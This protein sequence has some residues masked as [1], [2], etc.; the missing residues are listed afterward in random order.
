MNFAHYLTQKTG[1]TPREAEEIVARIRNKALQAADQTEADFERE[2]GDRI[3]FFIHTIGVTA[4]TFSTFPKMLTMNRNSSDF[5]ADATQKLDV[6]NNHFHITNEAIA[7]YPTLLSL[8]CDPDSTR[9]SSINQ[10]M[11]YLQHELGLSISTINYQPKLFCLDTTDVNN[12]TSLPYKVN[13]YRQV[14]GLRASDIRRSPNILLLDCYHDNRP[15]CVKCKIRFFEEYVGLGAK[16]LRIMPLLLCLDCDKNS[17]N[18]TSI[19]QKMKNLEQMGITKKAWVDYPAILAMDCNPHST[20]PTS[21]ASKMQFLHDYFGFDAKQVLCF[22]QLLGL[23]TSLNTDNPS[24][25]I[26]KLHFYER[27]IG[28]TTRDLAQFPNLLGYDCDPNSDKPTAII[29]KIELLKANNISTEIFKQLPMIV[30]M[31]CDSIKL[32]YMMYRLSGLDKLASNSTIFIQ[33]EQKT[34]SRLRYLSTLE[35]VPNKK[36][37]IFNEVKFHK[38]FGV[39][40]AQLMQEYPLDEDAVHFVEAE[41]AKNPDTQPLNLNEREMASVCVKN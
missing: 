32:R 36:S 8:D 30:A 29:K 28:L 2:F 37:I 31:P 10:K 16:Q 12:P 14:L 22:P 25:L 6:L 41:Y 5:L 33:N 35:R 18:D 40:T 17:Q 26:N 20:N 4:K 34:Y 27:E 13:F 23:D 3:D 1:V 19:V 39:T 24:A 15:T 38:V 11:H 21:I 9:P 7:K